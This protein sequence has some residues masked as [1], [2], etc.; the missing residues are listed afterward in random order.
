VT[1]LRVIVH[2]LDRTGPPMLAA[3][4]VRWMA[5][6]RPDA[7][8][9]V[10]AFRGGPLADELRPDAGVQVVLDHH[11]PWDPRDATSERRAALRRGLAG[12]EPAKVNLL[13][14][15]AAGQVLPLL[16]PVVGPVVTWSVELGEDLHWLDE[17]VELLERTDRW[18]AGSVATRVEL[19][20]RLGPDVDIALADE[21]VVDPVACSV[22]EIV[23]A[24]RETGASDGELLVLGAGIGTHRKGLDLFIEVAVLHALRGGRPARF[25]WIG[26][27]DDPLP[28]LVAADLE[29]PELAHVSLLPPV[30]DLDRYLAAADVFLHTARLDAFPLVCVSAAAAATPVVTFSDAGGIAEM[31][32]PD[33]VGAPFPAVDALA[34]AVA[35]LGVDERRAEVGA[36]HRARASRYLASAAVPRLLALLDRAAP[37]R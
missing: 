7:T 9:E 24:R 27:T 35:G 3:A 28:T 16:P 21:F 25:T 33:L 8:V 29:R 20:S 11:E 22:E 26:G 18:L 19:S 15:V 34:D 32:G 4:V 31:L 23:T 5:E 12:L 6:H 17:P 13:V 37:V 2:A 10:L 14:S 1:D 30:P 36:A